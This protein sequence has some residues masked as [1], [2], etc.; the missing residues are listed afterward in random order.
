[1][2]MNYNVSDLARYAIFTLCSHKNMCTE[3]KKFNGFEKKITLL[4]QLATNIFPK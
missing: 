1:M 4:Q 3:C 2:G